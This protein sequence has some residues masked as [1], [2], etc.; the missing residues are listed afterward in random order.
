MNTFKKG[1]LFACLG[2]VI[3][4][5]GWL[6]VADRSSLHAPPT[7][8]G[9]E[10]SGATDSSSR[11]RS[12]ELLKRSDSEGRTGIEAAVAIRS[13]GRDARSLLSIGGRVVSSDGQR[14]LAAA[15][16]VEDVETRSDELTGTFSLALPHDSRRRL[17]I[18]AAGYQPQEIAIPDSRGLAGHSSAEIGTVELTPTRTTMVHTIDESG[19]PLGGCTIELFDRGFDAIR[20]TR[21]LVND[22]SGIAAFHLPRGGWLRAEFGDRRSLPV[23]CDPS[24][25]RPITLQLHAGLPLVVRQEGRLDPVAG[26]ELEAAPFDDKLAPFVSLRSDRDGRISPGLPPG[27]WR[28]RS[29]MDDVVVV[30][31]DRNGRSAAPWVRFDVP[32]TAPAP[33]IEVRLDRV[34]AGLFVVDGESQQTV[35]SCELWVV[36]GEGTRALRERLRAN[37]P[38]VSGRVYFTAKAAAFLGKGATLLLASRSYRIARLSRE[39]VAAACGAGEPARVELARVPPL[40]LE[41]VTEEGLPYPGAVA[42]FEELAECEGLKLPLFRGPLVAGK[43]STELDWHGGAIV[44]GADAAARVEPD[45]IVAGRARLTIAASGSI[46]LIEAPPA[47]ACALVAIGQGSLARTVSTPVRTGSGRDASLRFEHVVPG[48]YEVLPAAWQAQAAIGLPSERQAAKVLVTVGAGERVRLPWSTD[49][50]EAIDRLDGRVD[51]HCAIATTLI[52][53]PVHVPAPR[54]ISLSALERYAVREDGTF[55]C[56]SHDVRPARVVVA[57]VSE[58]GQLLPLACAAGAELI[59][60]CRSVTVR[61]AGGPSEKLVVVVPTAVD[62]ATFVPSSLRLEGV[63]SVELP[64]LPASLAAIEVGSERDGV[65][66]LQTVELPPSVEHAELVVDLTGDLRAATSPSSA[67]GRTHDSLDAAAHHQR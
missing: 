64:V 37:A 22:E 1:T 35:S 15:I 43:P 27:R 46:E 67:T 48:R 49:W 23:H 3:A 31:G 57:T 25:D 42:L 39:Q 41:V 4:V 16:T 21:R 11:E 65:L 29:T 56:L 63:G 40:A 54:P 55:T 20:P 14:P 62:G 47:G 9:G 19:A 33:P 2:S 26:V 50:P 58:D 7:H 12:A 13:D 59:V 24:P 30:A 45:E 51:V 6:L 17:R 8:G 61:A 60:R 38:I 5:A 53:A 10:A 44:A 52:A 32:D 18:V 34:G 28:L 66:H 36:Q